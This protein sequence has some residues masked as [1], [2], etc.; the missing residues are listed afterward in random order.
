MNTDEINRFSEENKFISPYYG[1]C[2]ASDL[3]PKQKI[4]DLPK[5]FVINLCPHQIQ[6]E[7]CHWTAVHIKRDKI[8]YFDSGGTASFKK[9]KPLREFLK[10]QKKPIIFNTIQIQSET[11]I[12]CGLFCLVFL[13]TSA[14]KIKF[15][16]YLKFFDSNNLNENDYVIAKLFNCVFL[17]K[18]QMCLRNKKK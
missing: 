7:L 5:L 11:S 9:N 15:E 2:L 12:S 1:G 4:T 17:R 10:R 14:I 3:L 6:S 16:K 18:R 8:E 13:Y